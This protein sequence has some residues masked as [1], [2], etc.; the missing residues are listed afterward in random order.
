MKDILASGS[1]EDLEVTKKL[2]EEFLNVVEKEYKKRFD[3]RQV[4]W[5]AQAALLVQVW[6]GI[7]RYFA[8]SPKERAYFKEYVQRRIQGIVKLHKELSPN[9]TA[10]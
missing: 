9:S 7:L 5:L 2:F 10:T 6:W 1:K 4:Y 3:R 8:V